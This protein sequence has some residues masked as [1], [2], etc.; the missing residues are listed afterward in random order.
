MEMMML[1]FLLKRLIHIGKLHVI[2]HT[3]QKTTYT[4]TSSAPAITRHL[5]SK[6]ITKRLCYDPEM[7]LG[8]GYMDGDI[9]VEGGSIHDLLALLAAN[10]G[11]KHF[12]FLQ[13]CIHEHGPNGEE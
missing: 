13:K 12:S 10:L 1:H 2:D 6:K 8:E 7:A 3:G 5:H 4:G 11:S 9:T